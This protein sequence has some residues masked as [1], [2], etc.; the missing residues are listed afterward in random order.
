V[1]APPGARRAV[2]GLEVG[3]EV[4]PAAEGGLGVLLHAREA[5]ALVLGA[6]LVLGG[7]ARHQAVGQVAV[8][9][10]GA[11]GARQV[12]AEMRPGPKTDSLS[13]FLRRLAHEN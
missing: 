7:A 10:L 1:A 2:G 11:E 13:P 12:P 9:D 5:L 6:L 8:L 4:G 3:H